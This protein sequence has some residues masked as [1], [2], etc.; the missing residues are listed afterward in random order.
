MELG[1]CILD[2]NE[3][4]KACDESCVDDF[5]TQQESCPCQVRQYNV[6]NFIISVEVE[7]HKLYDIKY[8]F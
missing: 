6:F 2:C 4:S 7:S 3:G 1:E 5:R 8:F